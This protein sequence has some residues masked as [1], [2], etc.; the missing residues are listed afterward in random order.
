MLLV[1]HF[2]IFQRKRFWMTIGGPYLTPFGG[3]RSYSILDGVEHIGN[4]GRQLIIGY[5]CAAAI[6]A[7]NAGIENI[8]SIGAD[9]FAKLQVFMISESITAPVTPGTKSTGTFDQRPY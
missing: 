3:R 5:E 7:G 6:V 9:I 2:Y 8:Q 1:A 4:H